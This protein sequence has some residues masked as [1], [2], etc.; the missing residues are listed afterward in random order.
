MLCNSFH[1]DLHAGNLMLLTDGRIGFID[2]GIVGKL[3][4]KA[5]QASMG[6][7]DSFAKED[8]RGMAHYMVEMDM[9]HARE[10]VN[11]DVLA[12]DLESVMKKI[13][14]EDSLFMGKTIDQTMP[15]RLKDH[16]DE[17][18]QMLL[19]MVEVGKRHGIHFPRDFAL[20]TKQL[21]Y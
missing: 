5:W 8:Y 10:Q 4:P 1:A 14:A 19:E 6:M 9:T 12:Q 20:L 11:V 16:T 17:I 15:N 21:L 13:L 18:N 3:E 7:M 2:F